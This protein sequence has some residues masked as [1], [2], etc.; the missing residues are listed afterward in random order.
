M[1]AQEIIHAKR[2]GKP[3]ATGEIEFFISG[4]LDNSISEAQVAAFAMA[5]FF[6]GMRREECVSLTRS[7]QHSG[8]TLNWTGSNLNGPIV[9]KHSTGGVGDKVSI[10]LAPMLAAC[11]AFVPMISGRGLG[12]TGGT[13]DKMDSI[14]DYNTSPNLNRFQ[15]VVRQTGCA[16]VGQTAQLA[17]ADKRLYGIRDVTATVES[18]PLITASI[19]AKKL[20]AG[21]DSLVMDVKVGSGAFASDA[22]MA[23]ELATNI[24]DVGEGLGL[25]I[26]ALITDMSQVLG[27]TAGN[28]LEII[29]VIQYLKGEHRDPRLHQVVIELGAELLHLSGLFDTLTAARLKLNQCLQ[30]G[31]AAEYFARMVTGLGGPTDFLEKSDQ[32]LAPAPTIVPVFKK[33]VGE[34]RIAQIDVRALGNA[35]VELGGGRK[36]SQDIIDHSVGLSAIKGCGE[37]VDCNEPL[38]MVHAKSQADAE[39]AIARIH[40]TIIFSDTYPLNTEVILERIRSPGRKTI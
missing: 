39:R 10:M 7:L 32:Y 5:V 22:S 18:I 26:S 13:L 28:A 3:L 30:S 33:S 31:L 6:Q 37:K 36:R 21:L 14:P 2:E 40:D 24:V 35:V 8:S 11:G 34:Q 19:L 23:M 17:P 27:K 9:D 38:M 29:E 12:H 16:I 1:L 20:S 25:P 4:M 15:T